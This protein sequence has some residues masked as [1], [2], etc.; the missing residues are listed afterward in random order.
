MRCLTDEQIE[1]LAA[2]PDDPALAGSRVHAA[3]CPACKLRLE[4]ARADAGL[5]GDIRELR[6]CREHIKPLA[7]GLTHT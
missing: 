2:K 5:V 6:Q 1:R 3:D 4:Q 7:D